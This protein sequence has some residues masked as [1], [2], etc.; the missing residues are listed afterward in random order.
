MFNLSRFKYGQ[1]FKTNT[2][3]EQMKRQKNVFLKIKML[4]ENKNCLVFS[5]LPST[6]YL[7]KQYWS[8][9]VVKYTLLWSNIPNNLEF[10]VNQLIHLR[11]PILIILK[12]MHQRKRLHFS[13]GLTYLF[14][15][16]L[17][18][19]TEESSICSVDF[20]VQPNQTWDFRSLHSSTFCFLEEKQ[21]LIYLFIYFKE[22]A[23]VLL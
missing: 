13:K 18:F 15:V 7:R 6:G 22:R 11:G 5:V 1:L 19:V 8:C 14:N 20:E 23:R 3:K 17:I 9:T 21:W 10:W 12:K 2:K 16:I 4:Y